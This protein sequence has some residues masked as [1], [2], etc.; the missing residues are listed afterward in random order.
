M[1]LRQVVVEKNYWRK[2][3]RRFT[4]FLYKDKQCYDNYVG[5]VIK[6][7]KTFFNYIEKEKFID[8]G[9]FFKS[10]YATSEDISIVTLDLEQLKFLINNV[11]FEAKLPP[12]S[13]RQSKYLSLDAQSHF[14]FPICLISGLATFILSMEFSI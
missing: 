10:F 3:Y 2:F 14:V 6:N 7:I 1:G 11:E 4:D 9:D 8:A 5:H 13:G 12:I